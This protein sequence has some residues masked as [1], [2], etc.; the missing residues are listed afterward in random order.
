MEANL[1]GPHNTVLSHAKLEQKIKYIG[2]ARPSSHK[3][4]GL[5]IRSMHF[6]SFAQKSDHEQTL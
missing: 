4:E 1:R 5:G 2:I 6:R 3:L